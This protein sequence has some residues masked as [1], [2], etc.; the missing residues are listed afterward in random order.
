MFDRIKEKLIFGWS[1][2]TK[3]F[4]ETEFKT[5]LIALLVAAIALYCFA[6][7]SDFLVGLVVLMACL[8]TGYKFYVNYKAKHVQADENTDS[9]TTV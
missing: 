6:F 5:G 2:L 1:W 9:L 7:I 8:F 3:K 4:D